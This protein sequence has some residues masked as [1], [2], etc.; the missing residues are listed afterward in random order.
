MHSE[1][2]GQALTERKQRESK[3]FLGRLPATPASGSTRAPLPAEVAPDE[4][5]GV[6]EAGS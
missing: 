5:H 3:A 2:W 6:S 1:D 4:A